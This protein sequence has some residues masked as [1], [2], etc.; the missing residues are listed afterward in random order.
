[1]RDDPADA[2][3]DLW[4]FHFRD[5]AA[6]VA[7]AE[8]LLAGDGGDARARAWAHLTVA[9]QRLFFTADPA[10]ARASLDCAQQAFVALGDRRGEILARTGHA[11]LLLIEQEVEA[12]RARLLEIYPDALRL[13][14]PQDRFWVVNALGAT[15]YYTDRLDEAIRYLHEALEALRTVPPSPQLPTVMSNLAAALVTV[16]DYAPAKELARDALAMLPRY[17]NPRLVLFAQSN[18][19]EAELG[20]GDLAAALRLVD[21]IA[22]TTGFEQPMAAQGHYC[23]VAAEVYALARRLADARRAACLAATICRD[24]PG[25]F[26]EVYSRWADAVVADAEAPGSPV[27]I[28]A[29]QAAADTALRDRHLPTQCRAHDRLAAH[30]ASR[31]AFED[32]YRHQARLTDAQTQ[33]LSSR[34]SIKYYHLKVQHELTHARVERDRAERQRAES[35]ALN[36]QLERLNG[37]LV[38]RMQEV[39][40]LQ[41]QLAR[42]AV[43]DPLTQ[44][45]NRR[46]LL[47]VMPG[48][49]A[50]AAR[51]AAPLSIALIDLDHFKQ[52]ND[53][54]G[55]PAGDRVLAQVGQLLG[56]ALRPSD[57]VCRYGG[58]EFCIVLPDTDADGTRAALTGLAASLRTLAIECDGSVLSGLTF[59]GGIATCPE[60]GTSF[61]ELLA[62]ADRALYAAKHDG[63]DRAF[64]AAGH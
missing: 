54:H 25:G 2:D 21:A 9:F 56:G 40:E 34:A 18:L 6:A 59:S 24:H 4:E 10:A 62:A 44:L 47:T 31:G 58:E 16:G 11:R 20:L 51:R 5:P 61:E 55:H 22:A 8:A 27:A 60:R 36:R 45:F 28:A 35:E 53:R 38:A 48:L 50:G 1:M 12:A 15:Y 17:N 3:L 52:I 39:E 14:P 13:L 46:Y 32:A 19:A 29:L 41:A 49:L 23:A 37:E 30:H 57:V 33:R 42:E 64:V 26:N 43:R 63:R 7:R